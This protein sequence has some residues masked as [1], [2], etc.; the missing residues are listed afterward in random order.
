MELNYL[1]ALRDDWDDMPQSREDICSKIV[2]AAHE[3]LIDW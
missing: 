3:V 1:V 2:D